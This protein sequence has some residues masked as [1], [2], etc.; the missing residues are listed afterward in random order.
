MAPKKNW[1]DIKESIH[2]KILDGTYAPNDKLP[3]DQDMATQYGCARTT[4]QRAMGEL[5]NLGI[6]KRRRKGGTYVIPFRET[7][8]TLGI[9]II[10]QEIE[11]NKG[12]YGYQLLSQKVKKTPKAIAKKL[13]LTE[14][15]NMLHVQCVHLCNN[16]PYIYE[17]RWIDIETNP[18][19][20][21]VDLTAQSANE[22]LSQNRPYSH[23]SMDIY[24][25]NADEK[26]AGL[27]DVPLHQALIAMDRITWINQQCITLVKVFYQADYKISIGD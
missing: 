23:F 22:W 15:K 4:V 13:H 19:I 1:I 11:S 8:A 25:V 20:L 18:D 2:G 17:D 5:A 16:K 27:L 12:R 10:K 6:V 21:K 7:R 9:P 3:K 26:I 24:A 14:S